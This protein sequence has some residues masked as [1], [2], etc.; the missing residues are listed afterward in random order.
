MYWFII[1]Y[2][3]FSFPFLLLLGWWCVCGG[4][5]VESLLRGAC[6]SMVFISS[7]SSFLKIHTNRRKSDPKS[8]F[9][10]F[11][12]FSNRNMGGTSRNGA[13]DE[14]NHEL[15][16]SEHGSRSLSRSGESAQHDHPAGKPSPLLLHRRNNFHVS[17]VHKKESLRQN[18][19]TPSPIINNVSHPPPFQIFWDWRIFFF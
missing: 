9:Y 7:V 2:Y 12:S 1:D 3:Y 16:L 5:K 4:R 14:N 10:V 17:C 15:S 13:I 8:E 6:N 11:R 18:N 19:M